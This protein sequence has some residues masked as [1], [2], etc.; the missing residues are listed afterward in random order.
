VQDGDTYVAPDTIGGLVYVNGDYGS[1]AAGGNKVDGTGI[2]IVHNPLYNPREHDPADPL[3]NAAKASNPSVYGPANLGN[4]NGGTFRGLIIADK[5]DKIN[6]NIDI[7]GA[8]V[9]LTE[10]DVAKIGA[11]TA[12]IKYS[13]AALQQVGNSIP[14][15][16]T[17]LSWMAN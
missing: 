8:I 5:I 12:E 3:Y 1:G 6:G 7:F 13:C 15:P 2:L 10:I 17:R 14:V 4:I 16:P 11:G 9:S